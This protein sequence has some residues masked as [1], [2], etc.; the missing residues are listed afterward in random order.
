MK[1]LHGPNNIT[2]A[3]RKIA[4]QERLNG[5]ISDSVNTTII[6]PDGPSHYN[7]KNNV[8]SK[9]LFRIKYF[10]LAIFYYDILNF[11]AGSSFLPKNID[12]PIYKLFRKKIIMHYYGSE[13]RLM[14]ELETINNYSNL[15]SMDGKNNPHFDEKKI[16]RLEFHKKFIN[17]AIAPRE[18]S[19]YV[20]KVIPK[21]KVIEDI[22]CSNILEKQEKL[23]SIGNVYTQKK[24]PTIMHCPTNKITKGTRYVETAIKRLQ[25]K[26]V[27][28]E[29][30]LA[31]D[32]MHEDLLNIMSND[33]DIV[34][35]QFLVGSY[36]NLCFEALAL[37]KLVF[38]YINT[39]LHKYSCDDYPIVNVTI[40][41][42]EVELEKYILDLDL[43]ENKAKLGM[44]FINKRLDKVQTINKLNKLYL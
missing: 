11:H 28:F 10:F 19:Y 5:Y 21:E 15:F 37:G 7:S 38:C 34:L 27:E 23:I 22:W 39:E 36:A 40:D 2:S 43:R 14:K 31:E 26:G 35:D 6:Y 8:V 33:V 13:V 4:D 12:L 17:F 44:E 9:I 16:K 3:P 18:Y 20:R 32:L 25:A 30:I 24:I 42:L 41:D 1:I 29:F